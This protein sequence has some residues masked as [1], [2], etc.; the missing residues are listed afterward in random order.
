MNVIR[1]CKSECKSRKGE[2]KRTQGKTRGPADL[3]M[4]KGSVEVKQKQFGKLGGGGKG[5]MRRSTSKPS[6]GSMNFEIG[7]GMGTGSALDPNGELQHHKVA[8]DVR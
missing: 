7:K 4:R 1:P 6:R 3:A 5:A 8:E 2:R